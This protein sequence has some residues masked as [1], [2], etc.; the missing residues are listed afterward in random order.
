[1]TLLASSGSL[2]AMA[3]T[4]EALSPPAMEMRPLDTYSPAKARPPP[5]HH[6]HLHSSFFNLHHVCRPA[7]S[8]AAAAA[9][10]SSLRYNQHISLFIVILLL[11]SSIFFH[12]DKI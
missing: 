11:L 2:P 12:F 6:D 10:S 1:M 5:T 4:G 9:S 8:A 7:L 3:S